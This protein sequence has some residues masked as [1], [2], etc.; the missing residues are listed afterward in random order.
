MADD[1]QY[2]FSLGSLGICMGISTFYKS[3]WYKNEYESVP[4]IIFPVDV[5]V[6]VECS[7]IISTLHPICSI[8][9]NCY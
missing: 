1:Q 4:I 3:I 7:L 9:S 2:L 6:D 8:E 5:D